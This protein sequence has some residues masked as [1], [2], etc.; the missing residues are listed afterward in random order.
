M[1]NGAGLSAEV[2][3]NTVTGIGPT[4]LIAA[5]GIQIS[6]G[7]VAAVSGN[8][9]DGN[10][11]T[12]APQSAGILLYQAGD[13]TT[14]TDNTIGATSGSDYGISVV[15]SGGGATISQNTIE[16]SELAGIDLDGDVHGTTVNQNFI[17]NNAT[18]VIIE[19][20]ATNVGA[21]TE[22]SI[23]GNTTG[24]DNESSAT[25]D[26]TGDWWGSANGPN[27]SLNAYDPNNPAG[28][29]DHWLLAPLRSLRG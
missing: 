22:N 4:T 15:G 28:Q 11:Y 19:A 21:I 17:Q 23:T 1:V 2:E 3:N 13:G 25:M 29:K 6:R 10:S 18:G 16:N 7:A 20:T 5:N 24:L 12:P 9:I 14:V 8:T 27:S 26:A